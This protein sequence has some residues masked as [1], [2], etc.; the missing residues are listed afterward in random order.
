MLVTTLAF[1]PL[2]TPL[3]MPVR[4]AA[5]SA[6]PWWEPTLGAIG[7]LGFALL[8]VLA[9]GRIFRIGILSQGRAPS[10]RRVVG[11]AIR[12]A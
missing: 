6:V 2:M 11:W 8:C 1:I 10:L 5:S 9:A 4:I 12:G 7:A 3:V